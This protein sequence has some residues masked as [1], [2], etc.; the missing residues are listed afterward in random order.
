MT[1]TPARPGALVWL[2]PATIAAGILGALAYA[3]WEV[4]SGTP[5]AW[6]RGG[7]SLVVA[8][9]LAMYLRSLRGT[10]ARRLTP[11]GAPDR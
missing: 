2:H 7:A 5:G 4:A 3:G 1:T 11:G 6:L 10:L 8:V 9:G